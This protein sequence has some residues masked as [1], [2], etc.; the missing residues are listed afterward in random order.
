MPPNPV[1]SA[2]KNTVTLSELS[3]LLRP[4]LAQQAIQSRVE[5]PGLSEVEG[6][7]I[8]LPRFATASQERKPCH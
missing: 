5:E 2:W 4:L 3:I 6:A 7:C 1:C 8:S